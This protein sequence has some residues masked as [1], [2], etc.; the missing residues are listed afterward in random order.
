MTIT[1]HESRLKEEIEA[2]RIAR[3]QGQDDDDALTAAH[4]AADAILCERPTSSLDLAAF[5]LAFAWRAAG[6]LRWSVDDLEEP[7]VALLGHFEAVNL[8]AG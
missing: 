1:D 4:A 2:W 6:G 8:T 5:A 3:A 7:A